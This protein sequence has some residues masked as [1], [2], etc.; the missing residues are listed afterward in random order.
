MSLCESD[1]E[2]VRAIVSE[3]AKAV[4]LKARED[5]RPAIVD[6]IVAHEAGCQHGKLLARYRAA[7][8][9]VCVGLFLSGSG[10]GLIIARFL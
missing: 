5:R 3:A 9:G 2:W 1:R 8:F 6:A 4:L 7:A 10:V